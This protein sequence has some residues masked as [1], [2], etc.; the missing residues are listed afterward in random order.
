MYICLHIFIV[1]FLPQPLVQTWQTV[2]MNVK[3]II[4]NI[5]NLVYNLKYGV[6]FKIKYLITKMYNNTLLPKTNV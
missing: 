1:E 3:E 2:N 6:L 5:L 4:T